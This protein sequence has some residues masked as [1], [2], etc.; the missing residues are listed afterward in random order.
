MPC[1]EDFLGCRREQRGSSRLEAPYS[2]KMA[3]ESSRWKTDYTPFRNATAAAGD[4][5]RLLQHLRE[6]LASFS[7]KFWFSFTIFP[8]GASCT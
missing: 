1:F 3:L 5:K 2:L 8:T 6:W 4:F 7:Y